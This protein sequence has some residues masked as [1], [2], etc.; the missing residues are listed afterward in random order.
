MAARQTYEVM[1]NANALRS[2]RVR[3]TSG[4]EALEIA[5]SRIKD[6]SG[7]WTIDFPGSSDEHYTV[8]RLADEEIIGPDSQGDFE[9]ELSEDDEESGE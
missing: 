8:T 4:R 7:P 5:E 9:D 3:A 1:I 2:I 6:R